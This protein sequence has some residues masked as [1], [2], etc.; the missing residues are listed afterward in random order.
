[1][2]EI[3]CFTI[4][5]NTFIFFFSAKQTPLLFTWSPN[6]T[7]LYFLTLPSVDITTV[8]S[9]P[10]QIMYYSFNYLD[11]DAG[12]CLTRGRQYLSR[13]KSRK[14]GTKWRRW[15]KMNMRTLILDTSSNES[16]HSV[17]E[18]NR[19]WQE[20]WTVGA[21]DEFDAS[22]IKH[23]FVFECHSFP[24]KSCYNENCKKY[25]FVFAFYFSGF[26]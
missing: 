13:Q 9:T 25:I 15:A 16:S 8:N 14:S 3:F 19:K 11:A 24:T 7:L 18:G 17:F 20:I 26:S 5:F 1:M 21:I 22:H 2:A 12:R 23:F 10:F 4:N 6:T